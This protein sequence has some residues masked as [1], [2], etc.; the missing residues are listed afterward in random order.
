MF[1]AHLNGSRRIGWGARVASY[2]AAAVAGAVSLALWRRALEL[3]SVV[4]RTAG[5][6]ISRMAGPEHSIASFANAGWAE[7]TD[8]NGSVLGRARVM[9][10]GGQ[11]PVHGE[12][13]LGELRSIRLTSGSLRLFPGRYWVR[14][15]KSQNV[16]AIEVTATPGDGADVV[17]I[18]WDDLDLPASLAERDAN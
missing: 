2:L 16:H 15:E 12:A 5:R 9:L 14:F 13:L 8:V 6:P 3:S 1:P 17:A 10:A 18:R 11:L 4:R 7:I